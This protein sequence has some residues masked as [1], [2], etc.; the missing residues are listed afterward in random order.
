MR[1][2]VDTT[3]AT[4]R[5]V[6]LD[7]WPLPGVSS[8]FWLIS[9]DQRHHADCDTLTYDIT[10]ADQK[11]ALAALDGDQVFQ[12]DQPSGRGDGWIVCGIL[13]DD[14]AAFTAGFTIIFDGTPGHTGDGTTVGSPPLELVTVVP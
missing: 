12:Y 7:N 5:G 4:S 11:K 3:S 8:G 13:P 1:V 14:V 10:D 6:T 9:L 2:T